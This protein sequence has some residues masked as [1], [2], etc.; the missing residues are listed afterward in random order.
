MDNQKNIE[1]LKRLSRLMDE[2]GVD[3]T[4]LIMTMTRESK[5]LN[6]EIFRVRSYL[7]DNYGPFSKRKIITGDEDTVD[8]VKKII[9]SISN[10]INHHP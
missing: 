6:N 1:D 9:N 4:A 3:K 5:E 7:L 2:T 8:M 10:N